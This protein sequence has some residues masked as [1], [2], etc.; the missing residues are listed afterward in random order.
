[1]STSKKTETQAPQRLIRIGRVTYRHGAFQAVAD[2]LGVSRQHV[3]EVAHGERTS[4]RVTKAL[5][6]EAL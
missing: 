5:K 2:R 4:P 1:M 6:R 3:C